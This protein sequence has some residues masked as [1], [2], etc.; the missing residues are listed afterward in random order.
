MSETSLARRD[1]AVFCE[2]VGLDLGY[3]GDKIV[4]WAVSVDRGMGAEVRGRYGGEREQMTCE[5]ERDVVGLRWF[6]DGVMDFVYSSHC[7]E[8]FE[9]TVGVVRGWM[10]VLRVGGLMVLLLPDE[11]RYRR[12]CERVGVQRNLEHVH[13]GMGMG[14]MRGVM[15]MVGVEEVWVKDPCGSEYSFGMVVRKL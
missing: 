15:G 13:E 10:R 7:L 9:D 2:G 3:G 12:Y 11:G 6:G 8:D 14:Y 5:G 4:P 1:L